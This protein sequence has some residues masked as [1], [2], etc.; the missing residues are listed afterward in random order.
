MPWIEPAVI[1]RL[2]AEFNAG[3]SAIVAP[4][5]H[6]RRGH[7]IVLAWRLAEDVLRLGDD[8]TLKSIVQRYEAKEI[9]CD[10]SVLGDLDTPEDYRI[11]RQQYGC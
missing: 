7:P 4:T 10:A 9:E 2:V 5:H 1:D 8:E 11:A 6:G 3:S